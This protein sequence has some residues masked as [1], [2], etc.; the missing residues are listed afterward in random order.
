MSDKLLTYNQK[1]AFENIVNRINFNDIFSISFSISEIADWLNEVDAFYHSNGFLL[2]YLLPSGNGGFYSRDEL[3]YIANTHK[4]SYDFE[5]DL[6]YYI[7]KNYVPTYIEASD[8]QNV[9]A[10]IKA[11]F[12]I[13]NQ[14][15]DINQ[16]G[17]FK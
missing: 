6:P 1:M 14:Y 12:P 5:T 17:P 10:N 15:V 13:L 9:I 4:I 8:I 16:R 7:V 2:N 3:S 11:Y